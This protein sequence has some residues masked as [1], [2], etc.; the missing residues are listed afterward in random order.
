MRPRIPRPS[1]ALVV[2][3]LALVVAMVGTA[4]AATGLIGSNEIKNGSIRGIDVRDASLTGSDLANGSVTGTDIKN[5]SLTGIDVRDGSLTGTDVRDGSLT[6]A[7]VKNGSVGSVDIKNGSITSRD[8]K[9]STLPPGPAGAPGAPGS[10]GPVGPPGAQGQ[11]GPQGPQGPKGGPQCPTNAP[12]QYI[13]PSLGPQD[14]DVSQDPDGTIYYRISPKFDAVSCRDNYA[15]SFCDVGTYAVGGGVLSSDSR[16]GLSLVNS[17]GPFVDPDAND[18]PRYS[19]YFA[20]LDNLSPDASV[21]QVYA[22]C[23]KGNPPN[24]NNPGPPAPAAVRNAIAQ[25][26]AARR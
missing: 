15:D 14:N 4:G 1:P 2:A 16:P 25:V 3:F 6:G 12:T 17:V 8:I 21:F 5:G 20:F 11:P 7:D 10:T 24:T 22:V 9:L 26:K 13:N 18:D 19:G 23:I